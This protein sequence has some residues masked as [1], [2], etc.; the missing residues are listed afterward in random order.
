M[1]WKKKIMELL[2]F[3][4]VEIR[5]GKVWSDRDIDVLKLYIKNNMADELIAERLGRSKRAVQ[6]KRYREGIFNF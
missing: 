4:A 3:R 6:Q 2:G 5:D 1:N